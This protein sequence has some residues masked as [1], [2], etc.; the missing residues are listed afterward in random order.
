MEFR[1]YF[2]HLF[3]TFSHNWIQSLV[4]K[5]CDDADVLLYI[6]RATPF[7][8]GGNLHALSCISQALPDLM[9]SWELN[10][11]IVCIVLI[12]DCLLINVHFPIK[13]KQ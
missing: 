13:I 11:L 3:H 5:T 7:L 10:R 8:A 4:W 12:L 6:D 9:K 1:T 2:V